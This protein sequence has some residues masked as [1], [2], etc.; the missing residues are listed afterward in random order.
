[1][2]RINY[3]D[4]AD[5]YMTQGAYDDLPQFS[6]DA[7]FS[8]ERFSQDIDKYNVQ[9][10]LNM[11]ELFNDNR[12]STTPYTGG[13]TLDRQLRNIKIKPARIVHGASLEDVMAQHVA[14]PVFIDADLADRFE[15][16]YRAAGIT[17]PLFHRHVGQDGSLFGRLWLIGTETMWARIDRTIDE[18]VV[19]LLLLPAPPP[20]L[21]HMHTHTQGV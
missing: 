1:M 7:D 8:A 20:L 17:D 3:D 9:L 21:T 10:H 5:T 2:G 15:G 13:I 18:Y 11:L 19:V 6:W 16:V 14:I 4:F 12:W